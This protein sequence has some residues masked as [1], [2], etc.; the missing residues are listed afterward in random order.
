M[1]REE[2]KMKKCRGSVAKY[3]ALEAEKKKKKMKEVHQRNKI[4]QRK[5]RK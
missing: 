1:Q 5:S 4:S 2:V 3:Q